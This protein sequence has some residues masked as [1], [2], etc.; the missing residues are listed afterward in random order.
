[1]FAGE[2]LH[3]NRDRVR[4]GVEGDEEIFVA[5]LFHGAFSHTLVA[6]ELATG[7]L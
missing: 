5:Q 6:A 7:F 1:M 2:M 4:F 3:Q